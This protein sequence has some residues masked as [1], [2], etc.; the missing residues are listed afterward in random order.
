M[1]VRKACGGMEN[2]DTEEIKIINLAESEEEIEIVDYSSALSR[3]SRKF[4][5]LLQALS[6]KS[7]M[8]KPQPSKKKEKQ[9]NS[10]RHIT[11]I[12]VYETLRDALSDPRKEKAKKKQ[13]KESDDLFKC[14]K[15]DFISLRKIGVMIHFH[16]M[17]K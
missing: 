5:I 3:Q 7:V 16:K 17:H 6:S 13:K 11:E 9:V 10:S 8:K 12:T 1:E 14:Q 15:C 4:E 2:Q